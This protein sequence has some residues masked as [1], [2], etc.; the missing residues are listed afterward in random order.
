[1]M[2]SILGRNKSRMEP[3]TLDVTCNNVSAAFNDHFIKVCNVQPESFGLYD[4]GY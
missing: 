4:E 2:N 1:M 3:V